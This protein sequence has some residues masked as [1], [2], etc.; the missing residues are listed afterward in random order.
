[1]DNR[2]L[3]LVMTFKNEDGKDTVVTLKQIKPDITDEEVK[4][5]MDII[6]STNLFVS[7]GGDLVSKVKAQIID[8]TV[9]ELEIA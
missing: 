5:A 6:I 9:D 4:A 8:K 1:M 3:S 7:T 2:D